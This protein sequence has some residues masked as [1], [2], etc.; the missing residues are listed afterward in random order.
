MVD[1]DPKSVLSGATRLAE[2]F[3][4]EA[5]FVTLCIR[6]GM[7]RPELPHTIARLLVAFER[8]GMLGGA[9]A[10]GA[11]RHGDRIVLIDELGELSY[12][13]LDSRS[14]ALANAWREH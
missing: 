1:L 3:G 12:K 13:E 14:N 9:L 11:I 7:V 10:A 2:R 8:H 6:S 4:E 5:Y